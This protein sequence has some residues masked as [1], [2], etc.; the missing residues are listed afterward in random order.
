MF[1]G[2]FIK[3]KL[4]PFGRFIAITLFPFVFWKGTELKDKTKIHESIHIQQQLE[5][6]IIPFYIIYIILWISYG[7]KMN[8]L[9]REAYDN[10]GN[11]SY[12]INRKRYSWIKYLMK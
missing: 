4:L 7:Y 10:D 5:L 11:D 9:E 6:L 12:L 2:Y 1:K 3:N 8:P